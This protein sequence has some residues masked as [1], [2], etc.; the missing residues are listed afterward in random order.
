MEGH[1]R[2]RSQPN[3]NSAWWLIT[4]LAM[5]I[6][7]PTAASSLA[8]DPEV[9]PAAG[10]VNFQLLATLVVCIIL[11]MALSW[12]TTR[13]ELKSHRLKKALLAG[14]G[15]PQLILERL[16]DPVWLKDPNGVYLNANPALAGL[17]GRPLT[18]IIGHTDFELMEPLQARRAKRG[19]QAAIEG[20]RTRSAQ[21]WVVYASDRRAAYLQIIR[22]PLYGN[23]GRLIGLLGT[24][25]DITELNRAENTVREQET[26][27]RAL[28]DSLP[29]AVWLKDPDGRYL[30][31]NKAYADLAQ[32]DH[33]AKLKSRD[34][35]SLWPADI[36]RREQLEDREV[37]R[38]RKK[39]EQ[40]TALTWRDEARWYETIK[41]P[42]IDDHNEVLGT[43]GFARDITR[44]HQIQ[45]AL[46]DS[47]RRLRLA[48]QM[49]YDL[50]YE[51]DPQ[52]GT[53]DWF[54]DVDALLGYPPDSIDAKI[55]SWL[56]LIHS[57]D[58]GELELAIKAHADDATP[59]SYT[60]R[61]RDNKGHY[62]H[63]R[64]S[65]TP[66]LDDE[67]QPYRW[68]GVCRDVS[69]QHAHEAQLRLSASVFEAASEAIVITDG[70]GVIVD[71][72]PMFSK[73]TG[74]SRSE[75]VGQRPAMLRSGR[76]DD[77]FYAEMWRSLAKNGR[78]QGRIFNK[79]KNGE[80]YQERLSISAVRDD[81]GRTTHY[82]GLFHQIGDRAAE[83]ST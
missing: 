35:T 48:G 6:I 18:E 79:K 13:R 81:Q 43:V 64:D 11:L 27:Q 83:T 21:D 50:I 20:G 82:V 72:N 74:Y 67:G 32:L 10:D 78:W 73:I 9:L 68:V 77:D 42:V 34:D 12:S 17:I 53:I 76:Q 24:A 62:R 19:D 8:V 38:L 49:A 66:L 1:D 26:Y 2:H 39:R 54:G 65:A 40:T 22:R 16:P 63:W 15:D 25:R 14:L 29:F 36:A 3:H 44:R 69:E 46:S 4:M 30:A 5:G 51:W 41:A 70:S 59:Y 61:V 52:G 75:A 58:K 57:D 37:M 56:A 55:E 45:Q 23:D 71:T 80:L 28:L 31:A 47:E 33:P 60:Y 7:T